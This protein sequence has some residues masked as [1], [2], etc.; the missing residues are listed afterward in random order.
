[1]RGHVALVSVAWTLRYLGSEPEQHGT[2]SERAQ[3][4]T[5]SSG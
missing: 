5:R 3:P 4:S 2:D 1:M